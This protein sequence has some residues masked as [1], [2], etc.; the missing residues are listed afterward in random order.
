M[1]VL[2]EPRT[3]G[4][5]RVGI[6]GGG[7]L[8][9]TLAYRLARAGAQVTLLERGPALGGLAG[10]MDFAGHRVDRFYHC[11]VPSD[12]HMLDLI[13]EVG[14]GDEVRFSPVGVGFWIDGEMH[15]FNGIG[16]FLR[17]PPLSLRARLRLAWYVARCQLRSSYSGLE[18]RPLL[19][20]LRRHC[21]REVVDRIWRPLLDSRFDANHAELPATYL[22][23]RT[24]RMRNARKQ[25]ATGETMGCLRGGH[26]RLV[27]TVGERARAAG[28][29][30][31]LG[32]PVEG[33]ATDD[34]GA[35]TGVRVG[36]ETEPFDLTISTLQPPALRH[37]LPARHAGLL[38]AYPQR[39][40]G[41]VCLVLLMRESLLPYYSVNICDPTPITTIVEAAHVVG[42]EHTGGAR[43]VY[44]PK[45]C[46]PGSATFGLSDEQLYARFTEMVATIAPGFRHEDVVDWTVQ[47]APLVEPVHPR[48]ADPRIAPVWPGVPGLALASATQ[49]YPRLLSGES[50]IAMA[51]DVAT[52]AAGVLGLAGAPA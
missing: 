11:I 35:V 32:A 22:W 24:R 8:G 50:V 5:P 48:G 29:D 49:I 28:A 6:V 37:L 14:L 17:F 47:R 36:G 34:A 25:G 27:E 19:D 23:A 31:R 21:G 12:T 10:A 30:I 46:E 38:D 41:V 42:T 7:I 39:H 15:P 3:G 43:I 4:A 9:T 40:L 45:Y 18:D 13:D 1:S 44:V 26:E 51:E 33:L 2:A 16:D 52:Q 20:D